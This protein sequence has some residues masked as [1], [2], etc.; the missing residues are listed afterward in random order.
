MYHRLLGEMLSLQ[1]ILGILPSIASYSEVANK[2]FVN[3]SN[4]ITWRIA[5]FTGII[6]TV[7]WCYRGAASEYSS[8][9]TAVIG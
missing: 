9:D 8:A 5:L 2:Y 7:H 4:D 1:P 3:V 6:S